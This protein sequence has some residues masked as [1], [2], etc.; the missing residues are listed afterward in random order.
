MV[1][2]FVPAQ[3]MASDKAST[4][5]TIDPTVMLLRADMSIVATGLENAIPKRT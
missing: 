1:T 4:P 3:Y 2:S 5:A